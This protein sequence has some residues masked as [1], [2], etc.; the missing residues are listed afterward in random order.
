MSDHP[1]LIIGQPRV[2]N[3]ALTPPVVI[4]KLWLPAS[5]LLGW[6]W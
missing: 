1:Q 4:A 3:M 2:E 5:L 6:Q